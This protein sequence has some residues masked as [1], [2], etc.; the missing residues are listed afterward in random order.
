[1]KMIAVFE[2]E[3]ES[4]YM[5]DDKDI[6]QFKSSLNTMRFLV[7]EEGLGIFDKEFKLKELKVSKP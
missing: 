3:F 5:W 2:V 1:M 4:K 6:G 7:K